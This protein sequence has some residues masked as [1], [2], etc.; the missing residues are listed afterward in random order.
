MRPF[1]L[2]SNAVRAREI[3]AVLIR[4]GFADLLQKLEPPAGWLQRLA[5]KPR[6]RHT[7]WERAR[8]VLEELG[9]TFVKVGQM[10]SMRPDVLPEQLIMELRKLQDDVTP[11]PFGVMQPVL[12]AG[13][14]GDP[15]EVF[16]EFQREPVASA[17][18][19]Q[20]YFARLRATGRAVAV[21][22]QRPNIRKTIEAD[23][24]L[25]MWFARQAHQRL[26][27]LRPYN[28]PAIIE[29]LREGLDRELDFGI[30]ARN[31]L[32]FLGDNPRPEAVFAPRPIEEL[33]SRTVLVMEWVEGEKLATLVP[34]SERAKK[35]SAEGARS[36]FHQILVN[37][38]FHADPHG[39]NLVA[40]G[41][42]V[43]F[44]DW[45]L[46]GQLTQ[47]MRDSLVDLFEAFLQGDSAQV[48]RVA[49]EL[50]RS[51][52]GRPDLRR[53][54]RE[55]LYVLHETFDP[56][57]GRGEIGRAMLRLLHIFGS[58]GIEVAQDYALVAKA[59]LAV[60][61]AGKALDPGFSL[62]ANF[63]PAMDHLKRE[64]RDPQKLW[65]L[66]RRSL[67]SGLDRL[68][69]LPGELQRVLRLLEEGGVTI[70]F[71]HRGL[72]DL[73][74]A[75]NDASNKMT[76]GVII[77]SLIIGSSLI[78]TTGIRPYL[79]GYPVLGILGYLLSALLGVWV[80]V[81]I[82]RRGRRR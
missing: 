27:D 71:E 79:F 34:G 64:R 47:R 13:L 61:E 9:P 58:N 65:R 3:A 56:A 4:N 66:F 72:E 33:S 5:P 73:D 81:D 77:G 43:C 17:S 53:M 12:V 8:L 80:V 20:V 25:L 48:V 75:V 45:G 68:Q 52:T 46:V 55:I 23:F 76:L 22:I 44:L 51:N 82:L 78:V 50:G 15:E 36:I 31:A 18:L 59:V 67:T 28:L 62:R 2:L 74:D 6:E 41:D 32:L 10:L 19:G 69:E 38:F 16:S 39:G 40:V 57:S 14:D 37:G 11:S 29:E 24:E 1:E 7:I 49:I 30:E 63:E 35:L 26:E 42:R 54:E 60:E 21:K 70:K